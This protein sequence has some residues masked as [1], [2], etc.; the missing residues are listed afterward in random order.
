MRHSVKYAVMG[1][2]AL[3]CLLAV[4]ER[5]QA[6]DYFEKE[7][8]YKIY[9]NGADKIHFIMPVWTYGK[10]YDYYAYE[11]GGTC[12]Y[13]AYKKTGD[14]DWTTIAKYK[15][16]RY[17]ENENK[18][19]KKGTAYVWSIAGQGTIVVTS[20]AD[21]VDKRLTNSGSWSDK[22]YVTQKDDDDCPQVT[23]LEMDWYAPESLDGKEYQVEIV[24]HFRRSY[25]QGNAM[26]LT[27]P[28]NSTFIGSNNIMTPQ[29][30]TPYIYQVN[31]NG[32]TGYGY[33]AVPYMVFNDPVSYTTS[34]SSQVEQ[35]SSR[36]GTMYVMTNDTV[37]EQFNA[38]FTLWRNQANADSVKRVSTGVDIPPYHRIYD[39]SSSEET[40][41]TGTFTGNNILRWTVKNPGLKD[42]VDGDFFEIQRALEED[43]SDATTIEVVPMVRNATKS[44]YTYSDQSRATWT[45]NVS[46][47]LVNNDHLTT[48]V[49]HYVVNDLNGE[50]FVEIDVTLHA[51]N[52]S[53]PGLPVYYRIRRAS[54]SVWGWDQDFSKHVTMFK[55]NFLAPLA[56]EQEQYTLDSDY[57]NNHK[58]NFK[59]HIDNRIPTT[60]T[61]I[62]KSKCDYTYSINKILDTKNITINLSYEHDEWSV[63]PATC[64]ETRILDEEGKVVRSWQILPAGAYSAPMNCTLQTRIS[65]S[66]ISNNNQI[67]TY[68]NVRGSCNVVNKT[69]W[70]HGYYI[71]GTEFSYTGDDIGTKIWQMRSSIIDSLYNVMMSENIISQGRCMWDRTAQLVLQRT[72]EETGQMQEFIIPQD[73]IVRQADGSWMASFTD[74]ADKACSHYKYAVR[75]DQTRSD[76]HV[77]DSVSLLPVQLTG[78][79]LYFD[80]GASI[81][82]FTATQGDATTAMKSGVLLRWLTNTNNYDDFVVLRQQ[83]NSTDAA[84][85]LIVTTESSYFDR[86]ALP[87]EH[88]DYTVVARYNCN[89]KN[90]SN[91]ATAEGWR[92]PY[93]EI[94]GS[95]LLPDNTGMAGVTVALQNGEGSTLRTLTTDASGAYKFDSLEYTLESNYSVIPT[96]Q[97]GTF[98]FNNT[99]AGTASITLSQDNAVASGIDFVNTS[100][101]RLTGRV[102]YK[103]STIPVAGAVFLLNG[104]TVRRGNTPLTSAINGN[105]E[106]VVP[107][108]QPCRL[109]VIKDGHTFEGDG[110]L[111]VE[112]DEE[113]FALT[114]ALDGVRFYD[115]TKVRLVGRV[116]GGNDQRDLARAFGLGKNNIGDNV[117]LVLQLE[118][119]NTAHIVHDPDDLDRDTI[120]QVVEHRVYQPILADSTTVG[121][122]HTLFEKKR[123]TIQPDPATGEFAV[124]LFPV[125]YKVVQATANGYA[126]LFGSGQGSET[127]DLTDAPQTEYIGT[128]DK[129]EGEITVVEKHSAIPSVSYKYP[130]SG[131]IASQG[132]L[133]N[134][135]SVHYNAI[136]DR[137]YHTPMLV[138]MTQMIYGLERDGLGEPTMEVSHINPA[139][140]GTVDLY[141]KQSDGSVKYL[142]EHPV[143]IGGRKYQFVASAYEDYYYNNDP[144]SGT[145][146]RVPLRG[147]SVTIHNGMHNSTESQSYALDR[148][149]QNSSIWLM[150]DNIDV[151]NIGNNA[152]RTVTAALEQEGNIVETTL[153]SGFLTGTVVQEKDL[154]MTDSEIVLLDI[155]RDPGGAGSSAWI[156][157]GTT[158][159]YSYKD[160]Y[161]WETG[162]NIE[163]KYG[164]NV[165]QDVGIVSAPEGIGSYI[166]ANYTT[167]RQFTFPIPITHSW[168][169]GHQYDYSIT[170]TDRISTSSVTEPKYV[171][172]MADVFFGTTI[173]QVAGKAKTVSLIGDSLFQMCQP[174]RDAGA[175]LEIASGT[176]A[177]GKA[178]HLVTGQ[179]IVL[180]STLNTTFAYTQHYILNTVMPELAMERQNL[181]VMFDS[182]AEAQ[183]AADRTG[184]PVYWYHPTGELTNTTDTL[185][186]SYYEMVTPQGDNLFTDRVAA[187]NN[188][189]LEWTTILYQNEKE[190]VTARGSS[191]SKVGTYSVSYGATVSHSDSYTASANYNE[192]PQGGDLLIYELEKSGTSA[193]QSALQTIADNFMDFWDTRKGETFGTSAATALQD[194]YNT[195]EDEDGQRTLQ[196]NPEELGVEDNKSK[197]SFSF[198]PVLNFESDDRSTQVKTIKKTAGFN[199]V[200]DP[201]GDITVSVYRVLLDS[202]WESS[203]EFIREELDILSDDNDA[204][205]GSYVFVTEAGATFCPHE[206]EER[207]NFYNKGTLMS[208]G[209]QWIV[210]PQMTA[211]T[212]EITNVQPQNSAYFQVTLMNN[213]EVDTGVANQGHFL[214]LL[215]D[216]TTNP[217][218]AVVTVD[219]MPLTQGISYWVVPG[220]PVVKTVRVERGTVDDYDNLR[221]ILY[222]SD[223][224]KTVSDINL[225]VHF[226]PVS[227]DVNIA[228]PRQNWI[229]NTLSAKDSTGYYIPVD[230][231]GFDIHHKNFDHIEFQYKLSTESED[232]WV[233]QCSFYANDSL[234]ALATG[235]KAL[236]ENGRI[237]PFRFYGERDPMEQRYDLRAVSF[238]RY[239]SGFVT[240]SSAVISGTKDTRPP[241][242]FGEPEPVNAILG[243]G[244]NLRLRFNE[245]IAGNYLDED[246][247]FQIK[248][249]TNATGITTG[250]SVHFD[251]SFD[252]ANTE[253]S[254]S[255]ASKSFSIDLLI[256]PDAEMDGVEYTFFEHGDSEGG[257]WFGVSED[258]RLY[259]QIGADKVMSK[260]IEPILEFTRV[261]L[262]YDDEQGQ[263]RF[264]AGTK[265]VTDSE[266]SFETD[267]TLNA[268]FFFGRLYSGAMKEVRIWSKALTQEEVAATHM[269]RLTGY[270]RELLAYYTMDE[271][272]GTTVKDYA[273]GATLTLKTAS[274]N[275]PQGISLAVKSGEQVQLNGNLLGRSAVYDE[276]LML[277]FRPVSANGDVFKAGWTAGDSGDS[278][279]SGESG[280]LLALENGTLVLHSDSNQWSLG[281]ITENNWHHFVL[282]VNRTYNNVSAFVDGEMTATFAATELS[283]ITGAM[284]FGGNGFEGNIDE[285]V[286]FE[287][288]LPKTLVEEFGNHSPAGDEMGLMAYLP[289]EEQKQNANGVLELVFSA[290]D[291]RQFT[292]P[293]GNVIEK[294]VPLLIESNQPILADKAIYAPVTGNE[295]LSKLNFDWA[296]NQDELMINLKMQDREINKQ[297]VVV[298]VRDV[299][300]LNGNPMPS[301][302]MWVAYVDRNSLRW[303]DSQLNFWISDKLAIK[304]AD[305]NTRD[306]RIINNSGKRHQYTI[307]SVPD[308]LTVSSTYGTI[309][310]E[311]DIS[312][313][314]TFDTSIPVGN[315]SDL[316]YL[317]DENGLS[318]P[319]KVNFIYE[320]TCPWDEPDK[321]KY[322]LNMSLCGQVLIDDKYDTNSADKVIALYHNVCVGMANVAFDNLTNKSEV[323][324]TVYGNEAMSGKEITFQLWQA[325]TGKVLSLTPSVNVKFAHGNVYGCGN[326][327]PVRFTTGGSEVQ[328]ITL[329]AGWTWTS[330]NINVNADNTG[331]INNVMTASDPWTE[332][333]LIKNPV[334]R[335][336]CTYSESLD[337]FT[338]S[339]YHFRNIYTHMVYCKE[340]NTMRVT[341]GKLPQDSMRVTLLGG[342]KWS[343]LP[344]HYSEATTVTEALADYFDNATAGDLLKS[345]D[346]FAVFS[347]DKKW[348]GNLTAIRPGEGYLFRRM[349]EGDVVIHFYDKSSRNTG[350]PKYRNTGIPKSRNT[351]ESPAFS[352]PAAA[353]NMTMIARVVHQP[354]LADTAARLFVYVGS[355]LAGVAM[356]QVIDGD[357]LYFLTIQSDKAGE[358]LTFQTED[359]VVLQ[360]VVIKE[361]RDTAIPDY[362]N[363]EIIN[364]PDSHHG[365][366]KAPVL[367]KPD[368]E[369]SNVE[370]LLIDGTLYI[371]QGSTY[372]NATGQKVNNPL[373]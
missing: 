282:T 189:L 211:N 248:G 58:V 201:D 156:E 164:L 252:G 366:L 95:I 359:G 348:V 227:S 179:K 345:H 235:N 265:D 255:L 158:Y 214:T 122:T 349:G 267:Y 104:D 372:Y 138:S 318:E 18:D 203:T 75:I 279:N 139:L 197:L 311:D 199:I 105:F 69:W 93:G 264:F 170:T 245:P 5:A 53:I 112:G 232:M 290:N 37:Q 364:I 336:F 329:N 98:S 365:S 25:T 303:D 115:I 316:V 31:D 89:G 56:A 229:M 76:L 23:V 173:A 325:S 151:N 64:M 340:G 168:A 228:M 321:N 100:T 234:Y 77:Q 167:S 117:Q 33:A 301:P 91:S 240:K 297:T 274:W 222:P 80:E 82:S 145:L 174:A 180:G 169:W 57:E 12:S 102:L 103:N 224:V 284:Y 339:L 207:T 213:S 371:R 269:R 22:L 99:S 129:D 133:L 295:L 190:K 79:N 216:G 96:S 292:D 247:N 254:R 271:G 71:A 3:C 154:R 315:Y 246:N 327:E 200:S 236:I 107:L 8:H 160:S 62:D 39:F 250:T 231:D 163:L 304:Y 92:T 166:G 217:N 149:G 221:L 368:S 335:N 171:G 42:L 110:I 319:L 141:Q 172:A 123:I 47:K 357:T 233:N 32:P 360:P 323:F 370:K 161:E 142:L 38:T 52:V 143:F 162:L 124:D 225:S 175:M 300:D 350:I 275:L 54:S 125:K 72:I 126:T 219:G 155:I 191:V 308:W 277:W 309:Q 320:A 208:N 272:T 262:V 312:L 206:D 322:P 259:A 128:Y 184:E 119:D 35:I 194:F 176:T 130:Y 346:K 9:A 361:N 291:Q 74:V 157:S 30:Y 302:V 49:N 85:T 353:T 337:R 253:V 230:I 307:E 220:Q 81:T 313:T 249:V 242:V 358:K 187:L 70:S 287:Q 14:S 354:I 134:G 114:K 338:G 34:L 183:A 15:S 212:Y 118:G 209:T 20:I 283:G 63:D 226:L 202:V 10:S 6:N 101:T 281:A 258:N 111:R 60:V 347:T 317:T 276:T 159:S 294:V 66:S 94:S 181:L 278:G 188:M 116:A 192:M 28:G 205:Y 86:S 296:F 19:S 362:R 140:V 237:V 27:I 16:D 328:N 331:V 2:V 150:V 343:P 244:D 215:L 40:D 121:T 299:E 356:P 55:H 36:G 68:S 83:K 251:G 352:N 270:E 256:K 241:R 186:T 84:D 210:K 144:Q 182:K 46:S 239:G 17:D 61:S 286:I 78:P 273:N 135:D 21:G 136:Y 59:I 109:Q 344:C 137:I 218:G 113:E 152:L 298:T 263:V 257:I 44:Q 332:G 178:F 13:I 132:G 67:F 88:Y 204:L 195:V 148:Y 196:K 223:C 120:M 333:D 87:N 260:V 355:E 324:L 127:F 65:H 147:G 7:K 334:T 131:G 48:R 280:T 73:S 51:R 342:G 293:N 238:C 108:S 153:F 330:F 198:E 266:S 305:Y 306:I 285:F 90:T 146:D 341:G 43:F 367:L 177:D 310:P 261:I 351:E 326:E 289:F 41:S 193:G 185:P 165:S 363:T 373:K 4:P 97:Y 288:A 26:N 24:S 45:G 369:D 29:L 1:I 50:P 314:F 106:L 268:P 243:V 11:D